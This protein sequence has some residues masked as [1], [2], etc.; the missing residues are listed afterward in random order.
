MTHTLSNTSNGT[1]IVGAADTVTIDNQGS[2]I[3]PLSAPDFDGVNDQIALGTVPSLTALR[4]NFTVS[5]WVRPD[6]ITAT[7]RIIS[8]GN[9]SLALTTTGLLFTTYG[10]R[11]YGIST[12]LVTVGQW[13]H[14]AAMMRSD[15]FVEFFVNGNSM[16]R[17]REPHK[18][19]PPQVP[20]ALAPLRSESSSM[21]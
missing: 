17:S 4:N 21:V 13:N 2:L 16:E 8:G 15:N 3:R 6:P 19:L 10:I 5:A 12:S 18:H 9:W 14:V 20:L 7:R 1:V 11:D